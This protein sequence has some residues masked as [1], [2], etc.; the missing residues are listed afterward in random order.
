MT[1]KPRKNP[2]IEAAETP[3]PDILTL[4]SSPRTRQRKLARRESAVEAVGELSRGLER[5]ILTKGQFS[6]VDFLEAVS[7][8]VGPAR[9]AVATWTATTGDV[10]EIHRL[11]KAG[12]FTEVRWLLDLSFMRRDPAAFG[13]ISELFGPEAARVSRNHAKFLLYRSEAFDVVVWSS[14]NL[15]MNPRVEF[16]VI[17]EDAE[18]AAWL[19]SWVDELFRKLKPAPIA[20]AK[21][22][23]WNDKEFKKL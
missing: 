18:L 7:R 16:Y 21:S 8:Q 11:L 10:G 15:N 14:A 20:A 13:Q 9:F 6:E 3:P 1:L 2:L 22:R 19:E 23:P 5:V 12:A 17:R 4:G